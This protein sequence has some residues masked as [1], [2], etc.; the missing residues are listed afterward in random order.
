LNSYTVG[1]LFAGMGGFATGFRRVGFKVLWA[2]EIDRSATSTYQHN[3]PSSRMY[4]GDVNEFSPAGQGLPPPEVLTAGFPCQPFSSAGDRLGFGDERGLL[5]TQICRV[6]SEYGDDRPKILLLEN[7]ANLVAHDGGRT[8]SKIQSAMKD[9]GYWILQQ[10]MAMLNTR[11]HTQ[12]PHNRPRLFIVALS[13]AWFKGGRFNF[14]AGDPLTKPVR[15]FFDTGEKADDYYYFDVVSNRFGAMIWNSVQ[16]GS[17]DSVFQLRRSYVREYRNFVP[18]LTANMGEGGHNVPVIVD[19]WGLR[20]LTPDECARLQGFEGDFA[21]F[22]PDVT[23][24]QKYKQ[25]GN[26]VTVPLVE[27]L[28][29]GCAQLLEQ[30][31]ITRRSV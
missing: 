19:D 3:H 18:A 8:Y 23:R 14:P 6:V 21:S 20:K 10:N 28:A 22:P 2:N 1:S 11:E 15:S 5:Y 16:K 25:I 17:K 9:A 26:S 13:T 12:I 4:D 24:V 31:S 7:V 30:A 29:L 27:K